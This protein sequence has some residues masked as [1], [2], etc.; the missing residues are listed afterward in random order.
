MQ[1]YLR[2][3]YN[4]KLYAVYHKIFYDLLGMITTRKDIF[5]RLVFP[6]FEEIKLPSLQTDSRLATIKMKSVA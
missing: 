1:S 6:S 5:M 4:E 2:V 3:I